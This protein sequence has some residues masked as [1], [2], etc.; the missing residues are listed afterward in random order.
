MSI[1]P[2]QFTQTYM[3]ADRLKKVYIY[4][5]GEERHI[6]IVLFEHSFR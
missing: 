2:W 4:Q 1:K 5:K 3:Q 6:R